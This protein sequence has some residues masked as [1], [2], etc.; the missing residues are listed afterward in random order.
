MEISDLKSKLE[1]AIDTFNERIRGLHTGR[2]NSNLIDTLTVNYHG[3]Q[4]AIKALAQTSDTNHGITIQPYDPATFKDILA[5]LKNNK[6][7]AYEIAKNRIA[8][9]RKVPSAEDTL[10]VAKRIEEIGQ[11]AKIAIQNVRRNFR[12]SLAGSED[13]KKQLEKQMENYHQQAVKMIENTIKERV[14]KL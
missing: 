13:E 1:A 9:N 4:T 11:D 14:A 2:I 6:Y 3:Q 5:T 10:S 12:K 7:D 8:I